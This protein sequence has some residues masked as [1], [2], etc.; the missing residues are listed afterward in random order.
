MYFKNGYCVA[1]LK[2]D[3]E[4]GKAPGQSGG[5][6]GKI[7]HCVLYCIYNRPFIKSSFFQE[8]LGM[9]K[10][11]KNVWNNLMGAGVIEPW[12]EKTKKVNHKKTAE[13]IKKYC[14]SDADLKP[15]NA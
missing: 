1:C 10:V 7:D 9:R 15:K 2:F 13:I 4:T 3:H 12:G 8:E 6:D 11:E 14:F 5:F